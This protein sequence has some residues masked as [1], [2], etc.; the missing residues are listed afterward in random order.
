MYMEENIEYAKYAIPYYLNGT[1]EVC[2]LKLDTKDEKEASALS[3]CVCGKDILIIL[4]KNNDVWS[5][6]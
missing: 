5:T 1:G 2:L 4:D 6:K 3:R